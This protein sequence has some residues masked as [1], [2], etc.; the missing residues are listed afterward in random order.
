MA[1]GGVTRI[2]AWI[3][4]SRYL[5]DRLVSDSREPNGFDINTDLPKFFMQRAQGTSEYLIRNLTRLR[6]QYLSQLVLDFRIVLMVF[7]YLLRDGEDYYKSIT[8]LTPLHEEDKAEIVFNTLTSTLSAVMRGLLLTALIQG[9]AI[10]LGLLVTGVPYWAFL[11]VTPRR[12]GCCRS[13]APRWYGFR[14][15]SILVISTDW[16]TAIVL[17]GLVRDLDHRHR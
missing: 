17:A 10:G 14:R 5:R 9:V 13:A 2:N 1:N 16:T 3:Q 11:A 6:E 15:C 4:H 7:F 12:A 8:E